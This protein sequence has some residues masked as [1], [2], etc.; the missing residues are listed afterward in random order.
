MKGRNQMDKFESLSH[1]AWDCKYHVI[2]IPKRRRRTLYGSTSRS[3]SKRT[4]GWSNSACGDEPPP[5]WWHQECGATLATPNCRF[6]LLTIECL[7]FCR[8]IVTFL[9]AWKQTRSSFRFCTVWSQKSF[10]SALIINKGG[11]LKHRRKG[12]T[13]FRLTVLL[14]SIFYPLFL[15]IFDKYIG[16]TDNL[17]PA[18]LY[19]TQNTLSAW[20]GC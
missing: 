14:F 8:R 12:L 13:F 11:L 2:F 3:R 20:R 18:I 5:N 19:Q 4:S 15:S 6:E 1:T 7:Q 16:T 17:T 10:R 9:A